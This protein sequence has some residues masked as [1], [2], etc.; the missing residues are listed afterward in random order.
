VFGNAL[1]PAFLQTR[2]SEV[3]QSF[4]KGIYFN[5]QVHEIILTCVLP[6]SLLESLFLRYLPE[7]REME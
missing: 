1:H 2:L 3:G 5:M 4:A 6:N 7:R